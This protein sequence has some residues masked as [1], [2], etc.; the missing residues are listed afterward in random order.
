MVQRQSNIYSNCFSQLISYNPSRIAGELLNL[1]PGLHG[2]HIHENGDLSDDCKGSGGHYNPNGNNHG[3]P[4]AEVFCKNYTHRLFTLYFRTDM[5]G[6]Q[7]T[8]LPV[9]KVWL[10]SGLKITQL[11][12]VVIQVSLGGQLWFMKVT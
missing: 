11:S 9:M 1:S 8:L 3:A 6:T 7:A 2:F 12:S 5:L 4:G 10:S